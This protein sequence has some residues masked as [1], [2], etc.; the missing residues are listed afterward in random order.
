MWSSGGVPGV[1]VSPCATQELPM[2][3]SVKW[4]D[5]SFI[6]NI[7]YSS[8]GMKVWR[9]YAVSPSKFLSW[10]RFKIPESYSVPV[11]NTFE[12]ASIQKAQFTAIKSRRNHPRR[13]KKMFNWHWICRKL[14]VMR[15]TTAKSVTINFFHLLKRDV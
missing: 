4:D 15:V 2:P 13:N 3:A 11:P 5:V 14:Q 1:R 9:S 6:N 7:E 8:E 12:E 10:S